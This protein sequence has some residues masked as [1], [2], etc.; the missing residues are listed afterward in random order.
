[1][2]FQTISKFPTLSSEYHYFVFNNDKIWAFSRNYVAQPT[3]NWGHRVSF[4]GGYTTYFDT[5]T[6]EWD[7]NGQVDFKEQ[8]SEE[9]LE[10]FLFTFKNQIFMLLYSHFGGIQFLSLLRFDEESRNFARFAHVEVR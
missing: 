5:K 9:N 8:A 3:Y 4:T 1:M 7:S 10:E 2:E 6:S